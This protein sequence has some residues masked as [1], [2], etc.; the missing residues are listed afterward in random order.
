MIKKEG[1]EYFVYNHTGEKK[2]SEG[3]RT[4][5]E[6]E[7]RLGQIE[8][9]KH[10][11]DVNERVMLEWEEGKLKTPEGEVVTFASYH[12][13]SASFEVE[14]P[15]DASY[16]FVVSNVAYDTADMTF[17]LLLENVEE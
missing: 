16:Q 6:A 8:Y 15:L 1:S 2:L 13:L 5:E 17:S 12:A 4:K 7:K 10:E 9:F 3:Y 11:D 14:L